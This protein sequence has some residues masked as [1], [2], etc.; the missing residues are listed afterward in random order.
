ME[1]LG[2]IFWHSFSLERACEAEPERMNLLGAF[3][4]RVLVASHRKDTTTH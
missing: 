4:G 1:I 2:K 3:L